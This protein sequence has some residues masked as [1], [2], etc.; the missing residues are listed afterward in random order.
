MFIDNT[1][2]SNIIKDILDISELDLARNPSS[3][4]EIETDLKIEEKTARWSKRL[5]NTNPIVRY[6]NPV[7]HDNRKHRKQIEFGNSTGSI[8]GRAGNG[9]QHSTN[10]QS[11]Q[12][13][14]LGPLTNRRSEE[15]LLVHQTMDQW[16]NE[17]FKRKQDYPLADHQPIIK[18]G[19]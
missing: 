7:F 15:R 1:P 6:D 10:R 8:R 11:S 13:Q 12:I 16:R 3:K 9:K 4:T 5:T 14:M 17:R 19:M 18:W 2:N